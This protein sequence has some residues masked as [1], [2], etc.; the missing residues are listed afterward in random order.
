MQR[1]FKAVGISYKNT[2]LEVRES[3]A[4]DEPQTKRFLIQLKE[5]LGVD[6]ALVL[7]T[8]NRTEIYYF[9]AED[10]SKEICGLVD[11]FHGISTTAP[12]AEYFQPFTH[13]EAVRHLFEVALGLQSMVLG[14]IQINNQVKKAYQWAADENMAG[15][16]LHRLLHTIFY[17]NK[18]VVQETA[19]HDGTASVASAA[20]SVAEKFMVNYTAPKVAILGMGEIGQNVA[21]NLKG[22]N[23]EITLLNRTFSRAEAKAV[24]LGYQ[25]RPFD[26][27]ETV[28]KDVHVIISAVQTPSPIIH[29]AHLSA[30]SHPQLL[31]DLSVPRSIAEDVETV[32]GVLLYNVDQLQ[33]RATEAL[34]KRKSAVT[35]VSAIVTE[36]I[37]EFDNWSQEMEVSPTIKKFKQALEDIRKQELARYTDKVDEAQAKLLDKAT[38]NMIQKVIKLPVLQ[39]KAA[40]KR[41]DADSMVGL[42]ND[43]FNLEKQETKDSE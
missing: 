43:L 33:E 36:S 40:C 30:N 35:L 21:E 41:G 19:F 16:F 42:L 17:T 24:E 14:D 26:E 7:S 15:P 3:V 6:E 22:V 39:L 1:H 32:S 27:L 18:R 11:V 38:K 13:Q 9:A 37:A 2:P 5:I 25:A 4:F 34:E 31:I 20:A 23:A 28:L 29:G 8:C 12:S 10:L